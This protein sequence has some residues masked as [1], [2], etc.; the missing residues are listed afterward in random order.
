MLRAVFIVAALLLVDSEGEGVFRVQFDVARLQGDWCWRPTRPTSAGIE[1]RASTPNTG[2]EAGSFTVEVHPEWAPKGALRMRQLVDE[3]VFDKCRLFRVVP[4]P[5]HSPALLFFACRCRPAL[6]TARPA[7]PVPRGADF[8]V[9]FGIPAD[10]QVVE[11]S[12]VHLGRPLSLRA[13]PPRRA[14]AVRASSLYN[15]PR[16]DAPATGVAREE[17]PRR[18]RVEV[19]RSRLRDV[20]HVGQ[21]QPY[22]ADVHQL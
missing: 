18:S 19:Q 8:M 5:T 4:G 22:D 1:H 9:Q 20:C 10:P 2:G 17:D 12:T 21:E 3:A 14:L 7:C 13:R 6:L 15:W 16:H 11:V